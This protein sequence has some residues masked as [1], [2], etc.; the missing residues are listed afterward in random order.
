MKFEDLYKLL[1]EAPINDL[2]LLGNWDNDKRQG[3][4]KPSQKILKSEK[5]L[6]RLK[7]LWNKTEENFDIY[8]LK[9]KNVHNFVELGQV[10]PEFIKDKLGLELDINPDNITVIY[11]NNKGAERMPATPWT[12]AH[13]FGH[14]LARKKGMREE[15]GSYAQLH[16]YVEEF[17]E[18]VAQFVYNKNI[19][20]KQ[21][22][23][24][25]DDFINIQ[26]IKRQLGHVLG[27]FKSARDKNLRNQFEFTNEIIAQYLITGEISL[28]RQLPKILALRY[29]WGQ[30]EG[31]VSK[32]MSE[33]ETDE[34]RDIINSAENTLIYYTTDLIRNAVG[35]VYVM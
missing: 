14:A 26:Q 15:Y 24:Y 23:G 4:D 19:K 3:W 27:T 11:T 25:S 22:Y 21:K 20:T 2:Q 30:P 1:S 12:L 33:E 6:Q 5:G 8:L 16:K 7:R 31:L 28:N 10:D 13:R 17:F 9:D 35:N 32:K 29:N 18:E 34:L